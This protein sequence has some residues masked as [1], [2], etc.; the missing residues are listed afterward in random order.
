MNIIT[1]EERSQNKLKI[2]IRRVVCFTFY[3]GIIIVQFGKK[4]TRISDVRLSV[5][6][7]FN[8]FVGGT[9][10][11][12]VCLCYRI[13]LFNCFRVPLSCLV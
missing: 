9:E 11:I 4:M 6:F 8:L 5:H 1:R 7:N 12:K 3:D 2:Y 10:S 13:T